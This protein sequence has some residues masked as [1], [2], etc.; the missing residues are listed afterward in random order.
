MKLPSGGDK[1]K[2][3]F[4]YNIEGGPNSSGETGKFSKPGTFKE[5]WTS[6]QLD[7][8]IMICMENTLVK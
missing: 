1:K 8:I 4:K 6:S 2:L 7:R 3:Y 5:F